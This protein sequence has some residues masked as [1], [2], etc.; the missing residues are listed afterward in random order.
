MFPFFNKQKGLLLAGDAFIT[1]KQ[2][3]FW[4]VL[5]Q[6][7]E[8]N[9]P[10]RYLTP[11]WKQAKD[12]VQKLASLHPKKAITGHGPPMEGK[13]LKDGLQALVDHFEE[14]AVPD[15]GKFVN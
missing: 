15:Y 8:I 14:K 9:G 13:E 6:Y 2:D 10:P 7:A 11:D 3:S 4:K 5:E 12:S 1:V